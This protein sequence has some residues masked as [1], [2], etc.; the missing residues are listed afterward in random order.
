M[1][2]DA[3][4][5]SDSPISRHNSNDVKDDINIDEPFSGH[6][7]YETINDKP[8]HHEEIV[9]F[10][11]K[12]GEG[13]VK[14]HTTLHETFL[15]PV[16]SDTFSFDPSVYETSSLSTSRTAD[17]V[18]QPSRWGAKL[19][20]AIGL[21]TGGCKTSLVVPLPSTFRPPVSSSCLE[22][23]GMS[24]LSEACVA[25]STPKFFSNIFDERPIQP[26]IRYNYSI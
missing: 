14:I 13:R 24:L 11:S 23:N 21:N 10:R 19:P 16:H 3:D 22:S 20:R 9:S 2:K 6:S 12:S 4:V 25:V 7:S 26:T 15:P 1:S 17:L 8:E 18:R 5:E